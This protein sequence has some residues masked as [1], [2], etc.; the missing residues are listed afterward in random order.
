M[1][2][3]VHKCCGKVC[4]CVGGGGGGVNAMLAKH[5]TQNY[6]SIVNLK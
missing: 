2:V 1:Y 5:T 3:V 6:G 4:V